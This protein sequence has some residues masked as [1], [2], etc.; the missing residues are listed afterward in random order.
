AVRPEPREA[1]VDMPGARGERDEAGYP[2]RAR[3]LRARSR[4]RGELNTTRSQ[5]RQPGVPFFPAQVLQVAAEVRAGEQ[6]L[7]SARPNVDEPE[8]RERRRATGRVGELRAIGRPRQ[9][10]Y[11]L[12]AGH[13][14]PQARAT[15][16]RDEESERVGTERQSVAVR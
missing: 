7:P 3:T 12:T 16:I 14:S 11:L 6:E 4:Q 13:Q 15:G 1:C 5:L 9:L 10:V 2:V 8:S